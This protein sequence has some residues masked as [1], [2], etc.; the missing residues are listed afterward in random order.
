[1]NRLLKHSP[2]YKRRGINLVEFARRIFS[3]APP[4]V[5]VTLSL[6][7]KRLTSPE[8]LHLTTVMFKSTIYLFLTAALFAGSVHAAPVDRRS[9]IV[10]VFVLQ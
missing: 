9:P 7:T 1:M 8:S 2:R 6:L 3:C 4:L 5:L 10:Y